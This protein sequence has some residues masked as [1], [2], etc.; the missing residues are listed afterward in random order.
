MKRLYSWPGIGTLTLGKGI[1]VM[2]VLNVTPDSFSDGGK[3]N[4]PDKAMAH[5]QDM[6][7]A[8]AHMIDVGAESTRPGS[9]ALTPDEECSRLMTFLPQIIKASSVPISVDTYH[10]QTAEIA[11]KAGAHM[12]NDIWG[13]QYDHGEMAEVAAASG[14][15]LIVMHNHKDEQYSGDI[16]EEIKN[17]LSRSIEIALSKGV[18]Y[19]NIILDP[20]IGF[21]KNAHQN[22]ELMHR[23][24]E[25]TAFFSDLPWLLGVSRKRFIGEVLQV[26]FEGRDEGTVAASLYGVTKGMHIVRVHNVPV[27]VKMAKVWDVLSGQAELP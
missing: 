17:F 13:L 16:I 15:P 26:P 11:V 14:L 23:L 27:M 12:L 7:Q 18:K 2:G 22:V 21:A 25:L 5:M 4:V 24:G 19:E 20:G 10:W 8:G 9:T 3:W 1:I 6:I